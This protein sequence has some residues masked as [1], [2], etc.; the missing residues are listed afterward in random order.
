MRTIRVAVLIFQPYA[1]HIKYQATTY[2]LIRNKPHY[3]PFIQ[4]AW[5]LDH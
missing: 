2:Y 3:R 5:H 1:Q 4:L